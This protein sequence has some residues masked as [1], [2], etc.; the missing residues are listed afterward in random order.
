MLAVTAVVRTGF[1]REEEAR[2]GAGIAS[3]FHPGIRPPKSAINVLCPM[4]SLV[5]MHGANLPRTLRERR[6]HL[7]GAVMTEIGRPAAFI[8]FRY[9][10]SC[11]AITLVPSLKSSIIFLDMVYGLGTPLSSNPTSVDIDRPCPMLKDV[12]GDG[13]DEGL[14]GEDDGLPC[15]LKSGA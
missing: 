4:R 9:F 12:R 5:T 6:H 11:A 1:A 3:R 13:A 2:G 8:D 10:I 14:A 7:I 15:G